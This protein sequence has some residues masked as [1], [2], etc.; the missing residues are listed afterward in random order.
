MT[1]AGI[2]YTGEVIPC[3]HTAGLIKICATS[4]APALDSEIDHGKNDTKRTAFTID[5][6][7][8]PY[9]PITRLA[10]HYGRLHYA[11]SLLSI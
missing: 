8:V 11:A 1:N 3:L 5:I 9:H 4:L 10:E 6:A 2:S 7:H